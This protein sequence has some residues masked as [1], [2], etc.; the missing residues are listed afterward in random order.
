MP[1]RQCSGQPHRVPHTR[2]AL[3]AARVMRAEAQAAQ[4]QSGVQVDPAWQAQSEPQ[5]HADPQ[6]QDAGRSSVAA[7]IVVEVESEAVSRVFMCLL[8]WLNERTERTLSAPTRRQ[9]NETAIPDGHS[10]A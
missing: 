4:Q 9:L 3:R 6:P 1:G 2:A 5:A 7:A 8:R 10:Q